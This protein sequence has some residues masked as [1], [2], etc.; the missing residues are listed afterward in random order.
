MHQDERRSA[1]HLTEQRA[2]QLVA[3]P[4]A[5][6]RGFE[7]LQ[8]R[9]RRD[10]Q[11]IA[12]LE[13]ALKAATAKESA[14]AKAAKDGVAAKRAAETNRAELTRKLGTAHAALDAYRA[15]NARLKEDL[16]RVRGSR[17]MAI[18]RI[19]LAPAGWAKRALRGGR[20]IEGSLVEGSS[21][22]GAIE[23]PS[24]G[25]LPAEDSRTPSAEPAKGPES[26]AAAKPGKPAAAARTSAIGAIPIA[27]RTLE[28]LLSEFDENPTPKALYRVINRQWFTLGQITEPALLALEH[29]E[30]VDEMSANEQKV[31][32]L[33]LGHHRF[34]PD[35]LPI[36][37]RA[38]GIAYLPEPGRV[39][40]CVHSTP[41]YNSN[42]YST[43]TRGVA[44]GLRDSGRD[45]TVVARAGYPWDSRTDTAMPAEERTVGEVDGVE[46]VHIPGADLNTT[47]IDRYVLDAADA[48]VREARLQRPSVIHSASNFRTALPALIAA[49]RLGVP[50]VYEVRGLWEITE[51]AEKPGW[52]DT[53]RY[54]DTAGL[55]TRVAQEADAVLVITT[56]IADELER[57][58][59]DR[60]KMVLATNAVDP[61]QFVP[62]PRDEAFATSKKIR[63]DVPV[64]G[65]AGSI[66]GYE[67]LDT[68]QHA[69]AILTDRGVDHQVVIAGSGAAAEGLK[70]QRNT[71]KLKKILFLGRMPLKD[72]PRLLSTFDIAALPR[73]SSAVTEMVSP[74]KP[75]EAFASAKA[76]VLS[77]V[78]PHRDLA[79]PDEQRG[80]LFP[81]GDAVA[82]ADQLERLIRNSDLRADLGRTA[83]LWTL[84][85]RTW[86]RLGQAMSGAYDVAAR[87]HDAALPEGRELS[88]LRAG[89]VADEFTTATLA[90]SM[91]VIPL[92]RERWREQIDP[93]ELDFV[94]IESA[95]AGN[96]GQ[97]TRGVGHYGEEEN[98]DLYGLLELCGELSIPTVFWNKEDP[99]HFDR[100]RLTAARCDHVFTT[101]GNKIIDYLE[102]PGAITRTASSLPFYAQPVI[103]NPLPARTAYE[104]TAAYAGTYYGKR[105]AARSRQLE[106]L[107]TEASAY[108]LTIF[109]RQLAFPDSP[110]KFPA[111]LQPY[112]RGVLPYEQVIDSYKSHLAQINVNS[113]IDSPSMFSR[114]VVE[115]AACGGVVLSG[116][117]RG[118]TETFGGVI[119]ASNDYTVWRALLHD[120]S[121]HPEERVREAWLQ[122]RAV[123]RSHTVDTA[124]TLLARTVGIPVSA[125]ARATYGLVLD[126]TEAE[127]VT[128]VAEQSV[129]P[130]EVFTTDGFTAASRVLSP[131]GVRVR[132]VGALDTAAADWLGRISEPVERTHFEDLLLATRFGDWNRI[133]STIA[134]SE[135]EGLPLARDVDSID[136]SSGLVHRD[137]V[138]FS[139]SLD[140]ALVTRPVRGIELLLPPPRMS[141][142]PSRQ[143]AGAVLPWTRRKARV[144]VAGHDLKFAAGLI[145]ALR[146]AGHTVELDQWISHSQHDEERS[147]Q[148]L[149][150]ADVI[151]CEWGMRNA[152]WYSKVA[153]PHQRIVVRVHSQELRRPY[154]SR[155]KHANVDAFVFVGELIRRAAIESHKVPAE[156]AIV[157][158]N[159]VDI[160]A[161]DLPKVDGA[162]HTLGMVGIVAQ[163]KR[164]DRALDLLELLLHADSR[165]RLR[166]KGKQ[167]A[168]YPW[169]LNRPEEMGFYDAQYARIDAINAT[170]PGAV[171]FDGYGPDM[172]EW[173][174]TIGI[175]ISV[176]DFESFHLTIPDGAASGA[177]PVTVDWPGADLIYPREWIG[178]TVEEMAQRILTTIPD[179][180]SLA[181]TV[182]EDFGADDV[183]ADLV[184]TVVPTTEVTR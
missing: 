85:E 172:E 17:S 69:S 100:F 83:R 140:R 106:R 95:W 150:N 181:R 11:K 72:M 60:A 27:E 105:Y 6:L 43:R 131:L 169:M 177:L 139:N 67:G 20:T 180:P 66:V 74:L 109:D 77:D 143:K 49:R 96:G 15:E 114:R 149:E 112:V 90:A 87:E 107:L 61:H 148:L 62:L 73:V 3:D 108:G 125:P 117:G 34:A 115:V 28:A 182:Q 31:V 165:Y 82:L 158:P 65:F 32:R 113:V 111:E 130:L 80:L 35:A 23:S 157:I 79:G 52:E 178:A 120:W 175:A 1:E 141:L 160:E 2:A 162:E 63:T 81:A 134:G 92:D 124:L 54:R 91:T 174:R 147:R 101:D 70:A 59:V 97:W 4:Q 138:R 89:L 104:S 173:Y 129:L 103:H 8:G 19:V 156:K 154:L 37:E 155:I 167:P 126:G 26:A 10:K 135:S 151:L 29:P 5:V 30:L 128:S 76:V 93:T 14:S 86:E 116:P 12:N 53:D 84:D 153:A 99:V 118:V 102:T 46:Y 48:F 7:G 9:H 16:Q 51:A 144:I 145:E 58:G 183:L 137:L 88:S 41:V 75:L 55:E 39:L 25:A 133:S 146:E 123:Y 168:D 122:M 21:S 47:A 136:G 94:F 33:I 166:I 50:F 152:E 45:V 78:A 42:G 170:H 57:R 44:A 171:E 184:A 132:G 40:Y 179:K 121:T 13:A 176:S 64:I 24:T 36:P 164:L 119:P 22:R 68:L 110:Y 127:L 142:T 159:P 56:Q 98:A 161:L 163:P 38:R 71:Y 18:G